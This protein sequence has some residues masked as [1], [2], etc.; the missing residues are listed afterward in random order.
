MQ[1]YPIIYTRTSSCDYYPNFH[2]IPEFAD[3]NE[4]R[5]YILAATTDLDP[6]VKRLKRVVISNGRYC[7][8]GYICFI[9]D[10]VDEGDM[11]YTRDNK[12]RA[13]YGFFGFAAELKKQAT[14]PELC[15][16]DCAAMFRQYIIP[17]WND[18]V[19]ETV[20]PIPTAV[21]ETEMIKLEATPS[22]VGDKTCYYTEEGN[23][24][25]ALLSSAF[26]YGGTVSFCSYIE[27]YSKLK[28]C[29][30]A[31]VVTREN[32]IYRLKSEAGNIET[33]AS[34]AIPAISEKPAQSR[35][36][37]PQ[38]ELRMMMRGELVYKPAAQDEDRN[39]ESDVMQAE[40]PHV[41]EPKKVTV[42]RSTAS[43][44]NYTADSS[45][46]GASQRINESGKKKQYSS[47]YSNKSSHSSKS[48]SEKKNDEPETKDILRATAAFAAAVLIVVIAA[49]SANKKGTEED[50]K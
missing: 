29:P 27:D 19:P 7:V 47:S 42:Y 37:T 23:L 45:S 3:A 44:Q 35:P 50:G 48:C 15:T 25:A 49:K 14:I 46:S 22:F 26:T 13:V 16:E 11:P 33:S 36:L 43:G 38:E 9:K 8:W 6:T 5:P 41:Q 40:K 30:F 34:S 21:S 28:L 24:F 18:T 1:C 20:T 17:M 4:I 32:E 10:F 39:N 12:G 2:V 31:H